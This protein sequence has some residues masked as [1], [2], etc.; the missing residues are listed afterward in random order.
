[1]RV[2]LRL[3]HSLMN[4]TNL[5]QHPV[6]VILVKHVA[7]YRHPVTRLLVVDGC[8]PASPVA[9]QHVADCGA[10][11]GPDLV[12]WF[13]AHRV[14]SPLITRPKLAVSPSNPDGRQSSS[15]A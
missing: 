8:D 5:H 13:G 2:G 1:M 11:D 9:A 12:R 7:A 10:W 14:S 4:P 15:S 6:A 3:H